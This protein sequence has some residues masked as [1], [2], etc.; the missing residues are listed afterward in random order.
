MKA[1]VG[2]KTNNVWRHGE[3]GLKQKY[4]TAYCLYK[5][6]IAAIAAIYN[7]VKRIYKGVNEII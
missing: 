1:T 6:K 2:R 3:N 4:N 5:F 7:N